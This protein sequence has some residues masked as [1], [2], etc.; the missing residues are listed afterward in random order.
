MS[1]VRIDHHPSR[2]QLAVFGIIWLAFFGVLGTIA[3]RQGGPIGQ[4]DVLWTLALAVPAAGLVSPGFLRIVYLGTAYAT[5]PIGLLTSYVILTVV[6][7]LVLTPIG[8][9]M[10]LVGRDPMCRRFD[11]R[12]ESYWVERPQD[13]DQTRYFRQF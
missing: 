12:A 7:Y 2:R 11:R 4:A 8:L 6:F 10:R 9:L 13:D 5:F 1:L 3:L